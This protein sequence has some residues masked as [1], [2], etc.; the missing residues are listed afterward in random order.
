MPV[1]E[2]YVYFH[3]VLTPF[4][5]LM[6]FHQTKADIM[7][8]YNLKAHLDCPLS[9]PVTLVPISP[10]LLSDIVHSLYIPSCGAL[11]TSM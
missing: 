6:D 2:G 3:D 10:R 9:F 7:I 1:K 5:D 8:R 11:G 4:T